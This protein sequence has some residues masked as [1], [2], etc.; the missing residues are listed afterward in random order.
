MLGTSV[1]SP[2]KPKTPPKPLLKAE[3]RSVSPTLRPSVP[4]SPAIA[5]RELLLFVAVFIAGVT[6]R[7][8]AFAHSAVEHF[9]EGVYASNIYFGPPDYAYPLVRFYAPPLLPALIEAGMILQ[10][11]PNVAAILPSFLAGCGTIVALWWFGRSWFG[12]AAGLTAAALVAFSDF[13]VLFSTAALTDE[14]LGLWLVLAVD[15]AARS[16]RGGDV[17]WATVAGLYTGL[18]WWTKYN[19]WLPLAIEAAGIFVLVGISP[20]QRQ[21]LNICLGC[22]AVTA[23]VAAAVWSPYFFSLQSQGGYAPIA[24][25][26]A[27]YFVGLAGWLDS[28]SR[29]LANQ[30]VLSSWQTAVGIFIAVSL[31]AALPG[32]RLEH[33]LLQVGIAAGL[34]VTALVCTSFPVLIAV[35]SV[36][37]I[38]A[39]LAAMASARHPFPGEKGE[40]AGDKDID[41][42]D[43]FLIGLA[44]LAAWWLG[45]LL[46]TP[47]Y[48][49]YARLTLPFTLAAYLAAPFFGVSSQETADLVVARRQFSALWRVLSRLAVVAIFAGLTVLLPRTKVPTSRDRRGL[50]EIAHKIRQAADPN[51]PRL[52]YVYGEP[53]L[54][55]QLRAAGEELVGPVQDIPAG[56]A[57]IEGKTMP[58][59]FVVGPNTQHDA[60]FQRNWAMASRK[61]KLVQS[62]DYQP[63]PLVW[64]DLNDPRREVA[65]ELKNNVSVYQLTTDN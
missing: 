51:A 65:P 63:S 41:R 62:F 56:A 20:R 29:Q 64:L 46:T 21:R 7:L 19:G 15:A 53:A 2:L 60:D 42:N 32:R 59:F 5:P 22:F 26:H 17:R 1:S 9:D 40:S 61:W 50:Y 18:A 49:A 35:S 57:V 16:L 13:Q 24:D 30:R 23:V 45:L 11:P 31:P 48:T 8:I 52:V 39:T 10:L 28:T 34:G 3:H 14:L 58:T 25:N 12:P 47:C 27:K 37:L 6:L 55:F 38:Q 44:L 43:N 4:P 36:G 54:F 33:R